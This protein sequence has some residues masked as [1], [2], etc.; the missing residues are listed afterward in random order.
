MRQLYR[1]L[2]SIVLSIVTLNVAHAGPTYWCGYQ[3]GALIGT[4]LNTGMSDRATALTKAYMTCDGLT[5]SGLSA[6]TAMHAATPAVVKQLSGMVNTC[7]TAAKAGAGD[8]S[9]AQCAAAYTCLQTATQ[10]SAGFANQQNVCLQPNTSNMTCAITTGKCPTAAPA[11]AAAPLPCPAPQVMN[12]SINSCVA[13]SAPL[14]YSSN[15]TCVPCPAG[16]SYL[17]ASASCGIPTAPTAPV[18]APAPAAPPAPPAAITDQAQQCANTYGKGNP[19]AAL[20]FLKHDILRLMQNLSMGGGNGSAI[21][22]ALNAEIP[23]CA[24]LNN[25]VQCPQH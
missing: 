24:A 22:S 18:A 7:N 19:A 9:L 6:M 13:C 11:A 12:A 14:V 10:V 17:T 5:Q 1:V 15:G 8:P 3:S 20:K 4:M 2:A 25:N 21:Y 16:Q 23:C